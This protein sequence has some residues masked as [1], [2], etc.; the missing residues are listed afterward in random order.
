M[1]WLQIMKLGH[2]HS[3]LIGIV[4]CEIPLKP[5]VP[6]PC[7]VYVCSANWS[8]DTGMLIPVCLQSL[9]YAY[10][11]EM[12]WYIWYTSGGQAGQLRRE[13]DKKKVSIDD[14]YRLHFLVPGGHI[15]SPILHVKHH[16]R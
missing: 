4:S 6:L 8:S 14:G 5:P 7:Q 9:D 16:A 11:G 12:R 13:E 10:L 1:G 2:L 15:G 3:S